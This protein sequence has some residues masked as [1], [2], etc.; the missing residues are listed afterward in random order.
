MLEPCTSASPPGLTGQRAVDASGRHAMADQSTQAATARTFARRRAVVAFVVALV[1][2]I[3][4]V[5]VTRAGGSHEPRST[6]TTAPASAAATTG[7]TA[8]APRVLHVA[9]ATWSLATPRARMAA[10]T[11]GGDIVIAG[12]LDASSRSMTSVQVL[13]PQTGTVVAT[14]ALPEAVHDTAG[15]ILGSQMVVIG[16]GAAKVSSA[17]QRVRVRGSAV[18]TSRLAQLPAGRADLTAVVVGDTAFIV[19]GYDGT[20]PVSD[21]LAT[22]DGSSFSVIAHLPKPVRYPA[23][24]VLDGAI[25]V[26][27]GE[28]PAGD[29]TEIQ[30]IDLSARTATVVAHLA[31]GLSHAAAVVIDRAIY[32]FGGRTGGATTD[33]VVR[34]DVQRG[35]ATLVATLPA[36]VS[37]MAVTTVGPTVFLL[38][39][40]DVHRHRISYV[41]RAWMAP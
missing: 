9:A 41:S 25:Y 37:D 28:T 12:G 24:A 32:V 27:G 22:T 21:V 31:V 18:E 23:I 16:G 33:R 6:S 14:G 38:G 7:T 29:A 20:G 34:L 1:V 36:P 10:T 40:E 35:A 5:A 19:G 15:V 13:D 4:A 2:V 30:R 3:A 17:V 26:V 11:I 8:A 39:G